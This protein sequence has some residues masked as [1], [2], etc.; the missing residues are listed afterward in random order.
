MKMPRIGR[1]LV[2]IEELV[3]E[4]GKLKLTSGTESKEYSNI[5]QNIRGEDFDVFKLDTPL[6]R[7]D[8]IEYWAE[9][10]GRKSLPIR[11]TME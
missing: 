9:N 10:S 11:I 6:K 3:G 4:T 7:G 5:V 2:Y 8:I 1:R